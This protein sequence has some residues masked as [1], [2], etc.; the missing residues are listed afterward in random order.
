MLFTYFLQIFQSYIFYFIF[1][2]LQVDNPLQNDAR[3]TPEEQEEIK[4]VKYLF[5]M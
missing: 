5:V 1:F 3:L 4:A 2:L